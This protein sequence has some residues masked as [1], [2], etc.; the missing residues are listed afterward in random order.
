[1][2]PENKEEINVLT[3]ALNEIQQLRRTINNQGLRLQMFDDMMSIFNS[4]PRGHGI[5]HCP[6]VCADLVKMITD[7]ENVA[8]VKD[9]FG[10]N[11]TQE[12]P[13]N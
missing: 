8:K 5:E 9:H 3:T 12:S 10:T 13:A 4:G 1:M 11:E 7:K 2:K 6:D